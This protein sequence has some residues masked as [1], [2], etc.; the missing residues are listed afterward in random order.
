MPRNRYSTKR[1]SGKAGEIQSLP[2][3]AVDGPVR[4]STED[5]VIILEMPVSVIRDFGAFCKR[6]YGA[7]IPNLP[8]VEPRAN[9]KSP[10]TN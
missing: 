8:G 1:V 6:Y 9:T 2:P 10:S 7:E 4:V 5:R 3:Q